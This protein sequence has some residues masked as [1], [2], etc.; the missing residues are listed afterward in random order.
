MTSLTNPPQ[1]CQKMYS[2]CKVVRPHFLTNTSGS[3]NNLKLPHAP[4]HSG[5][6]SNQACNRFQIDTPYSELLV[7]KFLIYKT[8][9]G[10][11]FIIISF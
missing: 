5:H 10:L 2:R 8:N 6:T 11:I 1:Q 9:A 4:V 7:S 3:W